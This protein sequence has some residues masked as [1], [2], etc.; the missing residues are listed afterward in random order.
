MEMKNNDTKS[1]TLGDLQERLFKQLERVTA[2]NLT[3][4][5]LNVELKR[6]KAVTCLA[7]QMIA[8]GNLVLKARKHMDDNM[9]ADAELPKLL[10]G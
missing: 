8:N 6:S 10:E 9:N 1:H 5:Q 7:S 4:E 2:D 3:D